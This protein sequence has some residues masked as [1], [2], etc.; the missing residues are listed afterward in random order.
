MRRQPQQRLKKPKIGALDVSSEKLHLS[1]CES[2]NGSRPTEREIKDC[3]V[4]VS[5]SFFSLLRLRFFIGRRRTKLSERKNVEHL[6][7]FVLE[8]TLTSD[9]AGHSGAN[10]IDTALGWPLASCKMPPLSLLS[11]ARVYGRKPLTDGL[12]PMVME[13]LRDS[14]DL[15]SEGRVYGERKGK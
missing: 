9:A 14:Y 12:V 15:R 11:L 4:P 3:N 2:F 8:T 5:T 6:S 13:A 7:V 10:R 1:P